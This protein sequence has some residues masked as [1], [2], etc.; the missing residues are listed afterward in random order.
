MLLSQ[1]DSSN[2]KRLSTIA[3]SSTDSQVYKEMALID[4]YL[5]NNYIIPKIYILYILL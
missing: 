2:A 5:P 4:V 3:E 1:S